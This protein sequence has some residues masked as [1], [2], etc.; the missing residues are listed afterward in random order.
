[1]R[2]VSDAINFFQGDAIHFIVDK[3]TRQVYTVACEN[4]DQFI[5]ATIFSEQHL[6]IEDFIF[7]ED[8][9]YHFF[10]DTCEST[11]CIERYSTTFLL[12]EINVRPLTV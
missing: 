3:K 1:M 4:I 12:L 2:K 8:C 10:I 7:M 11:G 6:G 9:V 5:Y